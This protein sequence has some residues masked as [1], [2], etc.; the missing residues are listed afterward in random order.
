MIKSFGKARIYRTIVSCTNVADENI[1][2]CDFLLYGKLPLIKSKL[3]LDF[4]IAPKMI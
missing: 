2:Q 3:I 1:I 4:T